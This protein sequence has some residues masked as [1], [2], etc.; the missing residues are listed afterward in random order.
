M[1]SRNSKNTKPSRP[2]I[3]EIRS[4]QRRAVVHFHDG[5]HRLTAMNLALSGANPGNDPDTSRSPKHHLS[6]RVRINGIASMQGRQGLVQKYNPNT[7]EY[8]VILDGCSGEFTFKECNLEKVDKSNDDSEGPPS[9]ASRNR[10]ASSDDSLS[11]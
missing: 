2:L 7:K 4:L 6:E 8:T 10:S 3:H 1:A 5:Q 9:L 11:S